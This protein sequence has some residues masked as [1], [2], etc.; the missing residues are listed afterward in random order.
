MRKI[1]GFNFAKKVYFKLNHISKKMRD[2]VSPTAKILVYHRVADVKNDPHQLCVGVDNFKAQIKFLSENY[3]VIS[4]T[5]M[6]K[7]IKDNR[8][9]RKSISITFDDG[10]S[11]NL[12]NA[13]PILKEFNVPATIFLVSGYI[14][15][16]RPFY[17][18]EATPIKD[19]GSAMSLE[20][21]KRLSEESLIEMGAHTVSHPNLGKT[22]ASE[23]LK[24][25]SDSKKS[26]ESIIKQTISGFAY[27][28]GNRGSFNKE[29]E[30]IVK[31]SGYQYACANIHE[32]ITSKS[33]IYALPRFIIRDWDLEKFKKELDN[34]I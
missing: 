9:D 23:Q 18:D 5:T 3:K 21:L 24:E 33:N 30:D 17:W 2:S 4:L 27:P 29:T 10:Y 6:V 15:Q 22:S 12:T 25:I 14:G 31:K 16:N 7:N 8:I 1:P 26:L 28:F 20:E 32:R 11:D 34:F 13:L 19:R